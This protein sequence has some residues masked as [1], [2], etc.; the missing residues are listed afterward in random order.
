MSGAVLAA[1]PEAVKQRVLEGLAQHAPRLF[2]LAHLLPS[3]RLDD[4][5]HRIG[6]LASD[7]L[8]EL[9]LAWTA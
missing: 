4:L 9:M 3:D 6:E 1:T 8:D 5:L 2:V 7:E